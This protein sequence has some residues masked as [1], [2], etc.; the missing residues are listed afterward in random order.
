MIVYSRRLFVACIV[1]FTAGLLFKVSY[2]Q[3]NADSYLFPAV[4]A[5]AMLL[6]SLISLVREAFDLCVDDF[7]AF[8]FVRQLPVIVIMV[9]G[10]SLIETLGMYVT[11]FMLLLLVT[12]WYSPLEQGGRRALQSLGMAAGFTL[13]MYLLFSM[14]LKV[15]VPR[16]LLI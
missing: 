4:V 13:G 16:G 3:E 10:V 2:F 8:P 15:Q 12:F 9:A 11:T 1:A 6:F 5:S 7:Q 14:L